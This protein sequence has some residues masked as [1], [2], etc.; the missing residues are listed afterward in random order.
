MN[1]YDSG[2][3]DKARES[4]SIVLTG[5]ISHDAMRAKLRAGWEEM[6]PLESPCEAGEKGAT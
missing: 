2:G 4:Y 5:K 1:G 3:E 6:G